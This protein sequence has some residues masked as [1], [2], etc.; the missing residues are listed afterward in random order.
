MNKK[1]EL[2]AET[3]IYSGRT[4][5]RIR[6]LQDFGHV[7][8]G[9]LGGYVQSEENLNHDGRCWVFDN[10]KVFDNARVSDDAMVFGTVRIFGNARMFGS[11]RGQDAIKVFGDAKVYD[12][13]TV[14][15]DAKVYG[16][17]R[18]YGDA[19]VG[20]NAKVFDSAAVFE[21]AKVAGNARVRDHAKVFGNARVYGDARV[22]GRAKVY[23]EARVHGDANVH[24]QD[25]CTSRVTVF[26][27]LP[28]DEIT[29]TDNHVNIGCEQRTLDEWFECY[30]EVV[31]Q[32]GYTDDEVEFYY[33][34]LCLISNLPGKEVEE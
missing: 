25:K 14:F 19:C 8:A 33:Q 13:A 30:K 12:S 31:K 21:N 15:G 26:D 5:Y 10:A 27:G 16:N 6:A 29:V 32:A 9:E 18:V 34:A 3:I 7:K 24:G 2:T 1:Y 20:D 17:A 28:R 11:A 22:Y 4:L 23:G